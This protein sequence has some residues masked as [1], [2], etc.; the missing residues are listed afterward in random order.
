[1]RVQIYI[2]T[3]PETQLWQTKS[4]NHSFSWLIA[5]WF[6]RSSFCFCV[7]AKAF[8]FEMEVPLPD[9]PESGW[10][11]KYCGK[12]PKSFYLEFFVNQDTVAGENRGKCRLCKNAKELKVRESYNFLSIHGQN[13]SQNLK[14]ILLKMIF[15]KIKARVFVPDYSIQY[16]K[17]V[18]E[19]VA[20]N[21]SLPIKPHPEI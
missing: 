3:K 13:S 2:L 10:E 15:D 1:M 18:P 12:T 7:C 11:L 19:W 8:T 9:I 16:G 21:Q 4:I 20:E 14:I 5:E 17:S 6:L